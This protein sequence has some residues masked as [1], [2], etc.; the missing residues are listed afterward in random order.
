MGAVALMV[1]EVDTSCSGSPRSS[2]C[3]SFSELMLTPTFPTS[4]RARG[5][6]ASRPI[7]VGKSKATLRPVWPEAKR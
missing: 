1:M 6:S 3:M 5:W 7:C 2:T 4:P